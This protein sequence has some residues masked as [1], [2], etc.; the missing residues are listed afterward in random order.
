MNITQ[1]LVLPLAAVSM[2]ILSSCGCC[3]G[4]D[5]APK[6]RSL[7]TFAP[8]PGADPAPAPT[9]TPAQPGAQVDAAK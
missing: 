6:L 2:L 9:T 4:E 1:L 8:I 3:T 5:P 7:P